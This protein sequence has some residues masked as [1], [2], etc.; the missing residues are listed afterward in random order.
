MWKLEK[1]ADYRYYRIYDQTIYEKEG[2]STD[3][4]YKLILVELANLAHIGKFAEREHQG[5][6]KTSNQ[7][8]Q[9]RRPEPNNNTHECGQQSRPVVA[10]KPILA[11]GDR[12]S[13]NK[14]YEERYDYEDPSCDLARFV[15]QHLFPK[16][17]ARSGYD[18]HLYL[19][20]YL[21]LYVSAKAGQQSAL[22]GSVLPVI[23]PV[24]QR[25]HHVLAFANPIER[26]V[27]AVSRHNCVQ[28]FV[29]FCCGIT[30]QLNTDSIVSHRKYLNLHV[31]PAGRPLDVSTQL[32]AVPSRQG[33]QAGRV[34]L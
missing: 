3:G 8:I 29:L 22:T 26:A 18:E 4:C 25:D 21:R 34:G 17:P 24:W 16:C 19:L 11:Y 28:R 2:P 10:F 31:P 23:H 1:P 32:R 30:H 9:N 27:K 14:P 5:D 33:D 6:H 7:R 13:S 12:H 15:M 20:L